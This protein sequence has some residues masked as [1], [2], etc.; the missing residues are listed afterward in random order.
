[1]VSTHRHDDFSKHL[2]EMIL[3]H[4]HR[5][6]IGRRDVLILGDGVHPA[7]KILARFA[8]SH[9]TIFSRSDGFDGGQMGM[10]D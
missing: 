7:I 1:M 6:P 5:Q 8:S 4:R 10:L 3:K 2:R 9:A